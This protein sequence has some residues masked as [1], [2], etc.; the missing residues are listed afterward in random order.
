MKQYLFVILFFISF[1]AFGQIEK[2]IPPAPNPP[3]L[4]NDYTGTLTQL[5]QEMLEHKL[6]NYDDTTDYAGDNPRK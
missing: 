6:K 1:G 4:V 2:I 3:R 5:Q